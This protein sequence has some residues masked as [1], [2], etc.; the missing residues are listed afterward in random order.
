MRGLKFGKMKH[1]V[2]DLLQAARADQ[3]LQEAYWPMME[4]V[5]KLIKACKDSGDIISGADADSM[6][7]SS[8]IM[9]P[10]HRVGA[11]RQPMIADFNVTLSSPTQPLLSTAV[12]VS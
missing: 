5:G 10:E 7:S 1:G 8:K 6:K 11:P 2:A 12:E 4:A 9:Q 3:D